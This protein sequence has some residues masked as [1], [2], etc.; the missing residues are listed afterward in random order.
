M[1]GDGT[2]RLLLVVGIGRSGTSVFPGILGQ[3]GWYIPQP[4]VQADDT[5][6][7]GFGEPKW[8]VDFHSRLMRRQRMRVYD[9]RPRAWTLATEASDEPAV[10][11]EL[12]TWLAAQTGD[13]D[14]AVKDPRNVF[15]LPAW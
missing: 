11:D 5:N 13:Y 14:V 4:E 10:V 2:R 6:P 3:L 9:A 1:S 8:V 15:F 7:K 12:R